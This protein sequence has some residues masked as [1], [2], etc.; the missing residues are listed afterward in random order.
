MTIA[1]TASRFLGLSLDTGIAIIAAAAAVLTLFFGEGILFG[2]LNLIN[3]GYRWDTAPILDPTTRLIQARVSHG[4][5][6]DRVL[7]VALVAVVQRP[8]LR[9]LWR[10]SHRRGSERWI[11]AANLLPV[12]ERRTLAPSH[13]TDLHGELDRRVPLA[14][15]KFWRRNRTIQ[16]PSRSKLTLILKFDRRRRLIS[17]RVTVA[18]GSLEPLTGELAAE[19]APATPAPSSS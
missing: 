9:L 11:V 16:D 12:G 4:H 6:G 15:W 19:A 13:G 2:L 10:L 3:R 18:S 14:T 5:D 17:K 8:L 1:V 7:T